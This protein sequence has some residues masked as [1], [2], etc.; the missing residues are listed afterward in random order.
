MEFA[1]IETGGKQYKVEPGQ[2][3]EIEKVEPLKG[4]KIVFDKVLLVKDGDMVT[5]GK[6]YINGVA[7]EA[8]VLEQKKGK[9]I[10]VA[11]F[12]AKSRYRK[13]KGY[14]QRL[15]LVKIGKKSKAK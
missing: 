14:R 8:E 15:S 13:V 1:I 5:F 2:E 7:V 9:K 4:K 10:R 6:P 12:K 11:R 3:L